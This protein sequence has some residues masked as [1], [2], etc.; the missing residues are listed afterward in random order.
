MMDH[1]SIYVLT[2][3]GK[4]VF[5]RSPLSSWNNNN[6]NNN[7]DDD[8]EGSRVC[9]F[10]AS[11]RLS[12]SLGKLGLNNIRSIKTGSLRVSFMAV[13]S[14]LLVAVSK[15]NHHHHHHH[16][17]N[18]RVETE[19][20]MRLLLEYVYS[21]LIVSLTN[22]ALAH[23][24][25]NPSFDLRALIGDSELSSDLF[26]ESGPFVQSGPFLTGGVEPFFP[27]SP[28]VR[29]AASRLLQELAKYTKNLV[30]AFLLCDSKLVTLVQSSYAPQQ[31]RNP[32]L[33]LLVAYL[34]R[35][36]S[37]ILIKELWLPVCFP[38]FNASGFLHCYTNCLDPTTKTLLVLVSQVGELPQFDN[39]R[40]AAARLRPKLGLPIYNDETILEIIESDNNVNDDSN[41]GNGANVQWKRS[42]VSDSFTIGSDEDYEVIPYHH[43]S[44]LLAL[45]SE[46]Q[47]AVACSK[48]EDYMTNMLETTGIQHFLFRLDVP[49]ESGSG[50]LVQCV[51][52]S[53]TLITLESL[54]S[55][56]LV[57][58]YH[59][60]GLKLRLGSVSAESVFDAFDMMVQADET[61]TPGTGKDCL[62]M[63]LI[64]SPPNA[65]GITYIR[66]DEQ[67]F[68]ALNG[69][70][71]D[72]FEL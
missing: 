12:V 46:I 60:L 31:I 9:S 20:Y 39:F 51:S 3:A 69:K 68:L 72:E 6:N 57:N 14:L 37:A 61:T 23:V 15:V 32:D 71:V 44:N 36:S 52:S 48:A 49:I 22:Q 50:R 17:P 19:A 25:Q 40:T 27:L 8:E 33:H 30:F 53:D 21:T 54:S 63:G 4:P 7:E 70:G 16:H 34:N 26:L 10:L 18:R 59:Q 13:N 35:Q 66:E 58:I 41:D 67:T 38:R 28:N 64:E 2:D 5:V 29:D 43:D 1:V 42:S 65:E 24:S 56:E 47:L 11:L 55:R 45:L 62:A